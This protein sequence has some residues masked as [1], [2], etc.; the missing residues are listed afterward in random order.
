MLGISSLLRRLPEDY[1]SKCYETK[2]IIRRR[3]VGGAGELMILALYHLMNGCSL[4]EIS[5]IA[6]LS[7]LGKMS[8]VAFMKRF[9][10]CT[11]WFV[12]LNAELIES[13]VTR[14]AKPKWLEQ[15]TTIAVDASDVTEKGR[16]GRLYRLH[17]ALDIFN[18]KTVQYK[19][20]TQ[21]TGEKLQ[22]F[23]IKSGYLLLADRIYSTLNGIKHCVSNGGEYIMRLR[24]NSFR[25]WD[26]EGQRVELLEKLRA[27]DESENLD[28]NLFISDGEGGKLPVRVCAK[29]KDAEAIEETHKKYRR[30][31]IRKQET[32]APE[33][34]E[35]NEFIV[36]VTSL[37][38][39]TP[40]EILATY[41]YRWQV[42]IYFKRLKSVIG[43]GQLPKRR[44]NSV[45]AWLNGKILIA[46]LIEKIIS[47]DI[48]PLG[49]KPGDSSEYL[50]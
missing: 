30:K 1:E 37:A 46:L 27:L 5:E 20:T 43:Y 33:T 32:I 10:Q 6:R 42:E 26:S 40:E 8:D 17:F 23:E 22:N 38:E 39:P 47:E 19:I 9:E 24:K 34:I 45:F 49:G 35:F 14:F 15:Y 48:S 36:L 44:E 50:A 7:K 29:R 3:G 21:Q 12:A 2:A 41:R 16:S 4:T 28:M 18:M 11:E 31:S 25:Y 13:D